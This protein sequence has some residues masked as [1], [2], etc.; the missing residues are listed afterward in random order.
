MTRD[1]VV[2]FPICR[3]C[4]GRKFKGDN[5]ISYSGRICNCMRELYHD[6]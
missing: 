6:F 1:N 3:V 5:S 4:G 2:S